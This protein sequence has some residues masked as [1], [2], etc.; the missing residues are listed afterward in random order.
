MAGATPEYRLAPARVGV[1]LV[2]GAALATSLSAAQWLTY[3]VDAFGLDAVV[4]FALRGLLVVFLNGFFSWFMG[5]ILIGGPAWWLLH[6]H[7]FR[8]WRAAILTGMVLTFVAMLV[9]AIPIPGQ[10]P[11]WPPS[12]DAI[13]APPTGSVVVYKIT[14]HG[15]ELIGLRALLT[16]F[17]GGAVALLVWRVAYRRA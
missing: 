1:A 3:A 5:L 4:G 15:W 6:R 13:K 8:G 7:G 16:A 11:G 17:V 2:A 12:R 9:L 10:G 14:Q